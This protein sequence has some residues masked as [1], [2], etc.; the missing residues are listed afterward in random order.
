M[1]ETRHEQ[2]LPRPDPTVEPRVAGTEPA[3]NPAARSGHEEAMEPSDADLW[4]RSRAGDRDAF[5]ELFERH[6][7][8]I[9][10][11]CFRRAGSWTTAEDLLSIVFLEAWRRR[12]K[13]LPP[14]KVLPW[15]Y[16]I[17]TNVV[18]N[19]RRSERRFAAALGRLPR[20]EP[21]PDFARRVAERLDDERQAQ[22]ALVLLGTLPK[23]EQDVYVLCAVEEL[24]YEDA[25]LALDLPVG[26]VR[27]RL[28]RARARLRELDPGRGHERGKSTDL[29]EAGQP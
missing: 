2:A 8:A 9:Y 22:Q 1:V 3:G 27:S 13:T 21:E 6:A 4:T 28:S 25:A 7:N 18:R 5:G 15:L 24:P 10:N 14:A 17:A 16:G 20:I 12:D 19:H 11:Y 26:T 23:R 29:Q